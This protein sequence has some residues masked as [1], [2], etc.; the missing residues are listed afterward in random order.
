MSIK[1][2]LTID[3]IKNK[4]EY[5]KNQTY[6]KYML[7][8]HIGHRKL[9]CAVLLFLIECQKKINL[10]DCLILY[11][12]AAPFISYNVID[13]L[14]PNI[15]WIVYDKNKFIF[16]KEYKNIEIRNKYFNDDEIEKIKY[17]FKKS[18]KKYLLYINDMRLNPDEE[19]IFKDMID[20][21]LW[22]L[23][24]D[25][26][27]FCIKFKLPYYIENK[28]NLNYVLPSFIKSEKKKSIY[29]MLYL[30]GKVYLQTYA[31]KR[32][33]ETRLIS[34]KP[35]K[36]V[37]YNIIDYEQKLSYFNLIIRSKEYIYKDS[38][39]YLF[40]NLYDNVNEYYIFKKYNDINKKFRNMFEMYNF[41]DNILN[42]Y[43]I[44]NGVN[45]KLY[46]FRYSIYI[47]LT[48]NI[49][50][51]IKKN[52]FLNVVKDMEQ[53]IKKINTVGKTKDKNYYKKF[54]LNID[55][56]Y[57]TIKNKKLE[58]KKDYIKEIYDKIK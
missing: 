36:L 10:N 7:N 6:G 34:F 16:N 48:S 11:I 39:K 22:L 26:Y 13:G 43:F 8:C 53:I 50:I 46:N 24:L 23:K 32:S 40:L 20:Q 27:A 45:C 4:R 30:D 29:D 28:M 58:L 31:P 1:L 15:S 41:V 49:E 17:D 5:D 44:Y 42:K 35:Y 55:L 12:G 51:N 9:L 18:N 38:K 54:K 52:N 56:K 2:P 57:I 47:I 21:Q 33:L 25:P 37:N 14:Y 3:D 19:S